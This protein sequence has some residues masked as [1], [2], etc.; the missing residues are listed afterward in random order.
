M[1]R[2][3]QS[4]RRSIPISF[5]ILAAMAL[6]ALCETWTDSTGKFTIEAEFVGVQGKSIVLQKA[7][8]AKVTVPIAR[9]SDESR[10]K[11][12]GLYEKMFANKGGAPPAANGNAKS[13]VDSMDLGFE[14]PKPP[15]VL[16]MKPFPNGLTIEQ[17]IQFLKEQLIAGHPEVFWHA[18]PSD[19]H[20]SLDDGRLKAA[21][22]PFVESK[23]QV[24]KAMTD[25]VF[26]A[27]KVLV[28]K[29]EFVLGAETMQ[30]VPPP[31]MAMVQEAYDPGV[32][33]VFELV[34]LGLTIEQMG[35][36]TIGEVADYHGPRVGGHLRELFA[37]VPEEAIEG[38]LNSIEVEEV[39]SDNAI[40]RMP[41]GGGGMN[42]GIG[43][44]GP[45]LGGQFG[46]PAAGGDDG[47]DEI[48]FTRY[49]NRWLPTEMVEGFKEYQSKSAEELQAEMKE[50]E[51]AAG[52]MDPTLMVM[53]ITT[54]INQILDTLAAANTQAEFDA[55]IAK[56]M[57][58]AGGLMGMMGGGGPGGPGPGGPGGFAPQ[59]NGGF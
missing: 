1:H 57:E 34:S 59:P 56:A 16:P 6:P 12:K 20:A 42:F 43:G 53:M 44:G 49:N 22:N 45:A 17:T 8:G 38:Y 10:L 36:K 35:D 14:P 15:E 47:T 31:A 4:L 3:K 26:K 13:I 28:T 19:M 39:D 33:I 50:A 48:K 41:E 52:E 58:G 37:L 5:A 23:S 32:G 2:S 7:D 25:L 54:P 51:S 18:L 9:L 30:M 24:S 11:A 29:K 27:I 21:M 40:V 55:A 46:A